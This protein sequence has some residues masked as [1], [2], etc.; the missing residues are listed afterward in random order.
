[1]YFIDY[2][3][4]QYTAQCATLHASN[5]SNIIVAPPMYTQRLRQLHRPRAMSATTATALVIVSTQM[6]T[7]TATSAF[8]ANDPRALSILRV[9]TTATDRLRRYFILYTAYRR[10]HPPAF[11]SR[12][13]T[14]DDANVPLAISAKTVTAHTIATHRSSVS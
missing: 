10:L 11:F 4:T 12:S 2:Y 8:S 9:S 14:N 6:V 13:G 7:P 5:G 1:M 3:T